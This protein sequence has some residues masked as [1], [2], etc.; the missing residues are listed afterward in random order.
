MTDDGRGADERIVRGDAAPETI[1]EAVDRNWRA[2]VRAFGLAPTTVVHDDDEM[3]WYVT[4]LPDASFN[5]IMYANLAPE[6]V[7][8]AVDE[9]FRLRETYDV[10]MGWLVGPTSRPLDLGRRLRARGLIRRVSLTPMTL[11]LAVIQTEPVSVPG[12]TIERVADAAVLDEWIIAE[13]L[14]FQSTGALGRGLANLR[15]GMGVGH[16]YPL[17]HLLGRLDGRP[18]AT[19]TVLLAGGI[20][21]IFDVSTVPEARQRGLGTAMTVAALQF[22]RAHGYEIAFLQPSAMGRHLYERLGFR[23]CCVC[24]VYG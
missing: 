5:S 4:G 2:S 18:V 22:G 1:V 19:A 20:A 17:T 11:S 24:P 23:E 16:E 9:L 12:L 10:S 8:A 7:D 14:G 13:G 21:G 15:R 6:R 3:F